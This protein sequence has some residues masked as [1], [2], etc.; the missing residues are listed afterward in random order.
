MSRPRLAWD[1]VGAYTDPDSV[2][3]LFAYI[4]YHR[5]HEA[6]Y[7]VDGL[8][9]GVFAHDWRRLDA[10]RWLEMMGERELGS[11]FDP[12]ARRDEPAPVVALSQREFADSVRRALRDLHRPEALAT[13]PLMRSRAVRDRGGEQPA[14]DALR[15][16][17]SDAIDALRVSAR[18][19]KLH[20][21]LARTYVRP[22]PTQEAA[23][24]ALGLPFGTLPP[25]PCARER[26]SGRVALAGRA[27]RA[28]ALTGP[29]HAG[30]PVDRS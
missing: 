24:E 17:V 9:Y 21:A 29:A 11:G 6:E 5:A 1:F 12:D 10:N 25:P 28:R 22:A 16:L 26:A 4:D 27:L 20:R 7:E 14:P 19:E 2:E 13:N 3:L 30:Q 18:D 23:A 15:D 8:R